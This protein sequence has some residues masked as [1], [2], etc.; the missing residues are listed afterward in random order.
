MNVLLLIIIVLAIVLF[1]ILASRTDLL[2]DPGSCT[3]A[4]KRNTFSLSRVQFGIWT[5]IIFC[6]YIYLLTFDRSICEDGNPCDPD[7]LCPIEFT[8]SVAILLGISAG[9]TILGR[10]IDS[11]PKRQQVKHQSL[12]DGC[13]QGFLKDILSDA[14]G[15]S[16]H[17]F[18]QVL[19]S[20]LL[21]YIFID[22]M[23]EAKNF[24]EMDVYLLALSGISSGGYLGIKISE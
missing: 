10:S 4:G 11:Q 21:I 2:R 14:N 17:R 12:G 13:S 15:I 18:Q 3:T 8:Q 1:W 22:S 16:V 24:P 6:S 5:V 19:F 23:N 20:L 9:T 7:A